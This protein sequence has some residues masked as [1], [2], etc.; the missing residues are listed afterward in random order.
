MSQRWL[1]KDINYLWTHL[2]MAWKLINTNLHGINVA[3]QGAKRN[4]KLITTIAA[5]YQTAEKPDTSL[6][7]LCSNS[8]D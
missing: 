7:Y 6:V 5:L 1:Q 8:S 4:A 2:Y 3:N